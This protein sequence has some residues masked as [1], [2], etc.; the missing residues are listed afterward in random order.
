MSQN[1]RSQERT[2]TPISQKASQMSEHLAT[3]CEEMR[4]DF[5]VLV[6]D[7]SQ[8]LGD[9]CR[10]RPMVAGLSVLALGFYLGWKLR[11]W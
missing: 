4:E 1:T 7:M 11:P 2:A 9:Y 6:D 5:Q 10:K 8:S 3:E